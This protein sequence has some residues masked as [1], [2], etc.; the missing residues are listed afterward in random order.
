V[1]EI[2]RA[3]NTIY[4]VKEQRPF[5]KARGIALLM[6]LVAGVLALFAGLA[7]I[8][9][10]PVANAIGGPVGTAIAWLRLP[11]AGLVMMLLWALLYY[12]LPDVEQKFKFIT[13]GSAFGVVV[14]L[15][16]SWGFSVY[17]ANFGKYEATYGSVGGIIVMLLWMYI[18]SVVLLLGAEMNAIIE[19]RSEDGKR[20]GAKRLEDRG[21]TGTKT[22]EQQPIEPA[23]A[24]RRGFA[25]GRAAAAARARAVAGLGVLT[26]GALLL[27]RREV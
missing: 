25:A 26:V 21:A 22:Q 16:A 23:S 5:W 13:P 3:L 10:V 12:A 27:R 17:V 1:T 6:T 19:H 24:F 20:A 2:Q 7:A 14:W 18:S 9:A 4:G 15:I 11:V 8:A